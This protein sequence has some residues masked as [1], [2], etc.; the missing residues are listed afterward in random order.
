MY[1]YKKK[2]SVLDLK[3]KTTQPYHVH[4]ISVKESLV[5]FVLF[6]LFSFY[7]RGILLAERQQYNEAI[8]SYEN[9]IHYRPRLAGKIL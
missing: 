5:C 7:F 2:N 1:I 3:F 8:K 6:C 9:A 4:S